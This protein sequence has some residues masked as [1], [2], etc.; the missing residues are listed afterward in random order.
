[1]IY[2]YNCMSFLLGYGQNTKNNITE[3]NYNVK[4]YISNHEYLL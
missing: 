2:I 3:L 1:M 4:T